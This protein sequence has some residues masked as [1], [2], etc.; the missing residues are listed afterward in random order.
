MNSAEDFAFYG[1]GKSLEQLQTEE[2][3]T[4]RAFPSLLAGGP[5]S[6]HR[7]VQDP[8]NP[9]VVIDMRHFL[10]VGPRGVMWGGTIEAGQLLGGSA[11]GWNAQDFRSNALGAQFFNSSFYEPSMNN[12]VSIQIHN[13]L[14]GR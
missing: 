13:F 10:V 6:Q 4:L 1:A 8:Q 14:K 2:A 3:P 7:M 11:S 9:G 12:S 5:D